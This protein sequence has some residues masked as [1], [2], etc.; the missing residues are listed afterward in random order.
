MRADLKSDVPG[1]LALQHAPQGT[2]VAA[3][4]LVCAVESMK[5][6]Y[7]LRAPIAGMV[8]YLVDLGEMVEQDQVIATVGD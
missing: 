2:S 1:I 6:L 3:G 4:D 8:R 7:D 5:T